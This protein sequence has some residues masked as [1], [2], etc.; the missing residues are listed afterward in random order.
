M[1]IQQ[2]LKTY[3]NHDAFRPMQEDI[4]QSVLL[5]FDTLAL[6]PTGGGKSVCF[7]VP[8]L[9]KPGICI[10]VSPLI[11]LMKDQVENLK[12]KG[13]EAVAIVSGMGNREVDIA[14]DNCVYGGVKFLY[15][16]PERLLSELVQERIRY[17]NVNLLAV[18]EAH[19]ISQWGYDF[20]PPYLHI[21]YLR[22]LH[23][24]VPVLALTATATADVRSDIQDKLLFKKPNVFSKSFERRNIAYVVRHEE[25]K[26]R[27]LLEVVN[28]VKGSGIVYV[29]TRR[30]CAE[31]AKFL[32]N[33]RIKADMYHAGLTSDERAKKQESWKSNHTQVMVATNAF[34]MGIDKPDV[35]FVIHKDAPNSLEAYY[36]EAGR[37]GRDEAKAYAVLLYNQSDRYKMLK[38]YELSFPS[39]DEIKRIYS[40]I[41]SY[42]HIA[43]GAGAGVSFDLDLGDFCSKFKLDVTKTI[44]AF[45]FLER[46][47]YISFNESVFLPSRFRFEVEHETLY[48]FQI[49][50]Q[51]WDAFVKSILRSYGG[52]FES[53]VRLKEFDVARR[54]GLSVQQV[55]EGL[56]QLQEYGLLSYFPQNDQPQLTFIKPRQQQV[57]IN[58]AYIEERKAMYKRKM[59]AV[60]AYA[61]H[62]QCRS[63]LLLAYFD[64]PGADKCE[65]CDVCLEEKRQH[66][67]AD[68][69]DE[70]TNDI[71]QLLGS[72]PADLDNLVSAI[73]SGTEKEA[74]DTIRQLLDAGKI[75]FNGEKYYL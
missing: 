39:V 57:Y 14:L 54:S 74:L 18:D 48:N 30:E 26:L 58:T 1:T 15:L 17:M 19:C 6:L 21:A 40:H 36:Q 51:G 37:A 35:R 50:N 44:N 53:Y 9:A 59:E 41:G 34:G 68:T 29:Q 28:G 56:K 47:E 64:E 12:S 20:R 27:K 22:K 31:L 11:A 2:I 71:V 8:A 10:V 72:S 62:K 52:A 66:S 24:N 38:K 70:I 33:N 43:Y 42:Y 49:Q 5:G 23:P 60:F 16:S 4:I 13:I 73:K 69:R 3:W 65:V 32:V 25:D 61:S 7:Q 63:Q 46:D 45:K 75:R 55:I 67:A